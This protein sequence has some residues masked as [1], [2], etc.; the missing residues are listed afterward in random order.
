MDGL[1][2]RDAPVL[3]RRG[4]PHY[5]ELIEL[6]H[7]LDVLVSRV[8]AEVQELN[9]AT[10]DSGT[11]IAEHQTSIK[12]RIAKWREV[13]DSCVREVLDYQKSRNPDRSPVLLGKAGFNATI[14]GDLIE[15]TEKLTGFMAKVC[16]TKASR[17]YHMCLMTKK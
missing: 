12:N 1:I 5:G 3:K 13:Q 4:L 9:A 17:Q 7:W 14:D 8:D 2:D 10:P 16:C 15:E 6:L 11:L